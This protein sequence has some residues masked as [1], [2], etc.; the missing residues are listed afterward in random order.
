MGQ[1]HQSL[2]HHYRIKVNMSG[3]PHTVILGAG[4]VGL[5][6]A[7]AL[8]RRRHAVTLID[9]SDPGL[10]CSFGNAGCFSLASIV[11]VGMPG[12]WR[13]V[14]GW[15]LDPAGP[16]SIPPSY[17]RHIA[18]WIFKLLRSSTTQ[19][20]QAIADD[21]HTLLAPTLDYWRPLAA[22]AG[23]PQLIQQNGWAVA[24]E[25]AAAFE[26]DRFGWDL[27][28]AHGVQIEILQGP[29]I[30]DLEPSLAPRYTH[31]A[32]LPEQ[33]QCLNPLRL[34]QA[35]AATL[36]DHGAHFVKASAKA[37]IFREGKVAAVVTDQGQFAADHVV[38]SA[39]AHSRPLASE[40]GNDLPL[41]TE[42]GYHVMVKTPQSTVR[43]PVMSGEGKFFATPMEEGVRFAGSVELGGLNLP[44]NF[45]RADILLQKGKAMLPGL[46][47]EHTSQWMG[48]RPSLP[49]SKPIIGP[50]RNAANAYYAFGHGHVGLTAA[51]ATGDIVADLISG[52]QPKIDPA[53]FLPDRF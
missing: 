8:V 9:P 37:F 13:K 40:L 49:D 53:P 47:I 38:V 24:Y 45:Q 27:R 21:L 20:V 10:G 29:A 12:M 41:E 17:A 6:T 51:A 16:L 11:P 52:R 35:L 50:S 34:S 28:A 46:D 14:P 42:R 30:Q 33:A 44:P 23:V 4:V 15:L 31:M 26:G 2:R 19:R 32:Y 25:S 48:F 1:D 18:P 43:R 7:A 22:W 39:G 3:K 36:K 5:A